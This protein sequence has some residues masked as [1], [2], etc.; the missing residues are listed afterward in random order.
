M[1]TLLDTKDKLIK[2]TYNI[3]ETYNCQIRANNPNRSSAR[4]KTIG[5]ISVVI[6]WFS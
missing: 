6:P 3:T 1:C 5:I 2:Q 4:D